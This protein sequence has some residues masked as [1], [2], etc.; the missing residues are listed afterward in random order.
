MYRQ[1]MLKMMVL[2]MN[3]HDQL[4]FDVVAHQQLALIGIHPKDSYN[5]HSQASMVLKMS[6]VFNKH[7][8]HLLNRM[9]IVFLSFFVICMVFVSSFTIQL[10]LDANVDITL[11][12]IAIC[13]I[14]VIVFMFI[15]PNM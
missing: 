14:E 8:I 7:F 15:V 2:V 1:C 6:L 12:C 9:C 5:I 3:K 13:R 4:T 10:M 11:P